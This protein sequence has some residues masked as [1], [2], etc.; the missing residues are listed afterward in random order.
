MLLIHNIMDDNG[1]CF[2]K[3]KNEKHLLEHKAL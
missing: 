2:Q 3:K 1:G